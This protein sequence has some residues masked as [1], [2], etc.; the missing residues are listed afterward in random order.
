MNFEAYLTRAENHASAVTEEHCRELASGQNPDVLFITCSDSRVLPSRL[1]GAEPGQLF[2]LRTAGNA[3]P[4]YL[5]D[6]GSS[7]MATIEYAVLRL[8]VPNIVVCGHSHCGAVTAM[9]SAGRG[10]TDMPAL[11]TWFGLSGG[12]GGDGA[13][14]D[15]AVRAESQQHVRDQLAELRA[16]P[17]VRDRLANGELALR[18]WFFELDTGRVHTLECGSDAADANTAVFRPL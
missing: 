12:A 11:C 13:A 17:F 10:L 14:V 9:A 15:P 2:E 3:V 6:R 18:G 7:E 1:T 8:G 5:P 16:Y 4:E